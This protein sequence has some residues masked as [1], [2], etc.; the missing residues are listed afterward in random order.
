VKITNASDNT[1]R[2]DF[3]PVVLHWVG[4]THNP[5]DINKNEHELLDLFHTRDD[6]PVHF[7]IVPEE[8]ESR[9]INL[10]PPR[11]D[12]ILRVVLYGANVEPLAK[13]YYVKN[14]LVFDQ[15]EITEKV[16]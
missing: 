16:T 10:T 2:T 15:V 8:K 5:I 13:N 12:C 4:S 7:H 9:S 6:D 1:D 14:S 11:Q 3:D